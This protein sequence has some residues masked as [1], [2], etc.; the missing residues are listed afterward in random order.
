MRRKAEVYVH[1]KTGPALGP[2]EPQGRGPPRYS[3][4]RRIKAGENLKDFLIFFLV[5]SRN[6][7]NEMAA[8]SPV[9]A[10]EASP[11]TGQSPT[12]VSRIKRMKMI[13]K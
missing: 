2:G 7:Q 3:K 6:C 10:C 12:W 13:N 11:T 1:R 9:T 4:A 8:G 5:V